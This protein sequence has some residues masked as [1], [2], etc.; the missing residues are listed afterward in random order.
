MSKNFIDEVLNNAPKLVV[1]LL[2]LL[3]LI[4]VSPGLIGGGSPTSTPLPTVPPR[5]LANSEN[6]PWNEIWRKPVYLRRSFQNIRNLIAADEGVLFMDYTNG[7]WL[8]FAEAENGDMRWRVDLNG[9]VDSMVSDGNQVYVFGNAGQ[10][11]DA[12]NLLNGNL[13]WKANV[14]LPDHRGYSANLQENILYVYDT[15]NHL[16]SISSESGSLIKDMSPPNFG[17]EFLSNIEG[18][19]WL[20]SKDKQIILANGEEIMWQ[21]ELN[22]APQKFPYIYKNMVIVR[23]EN[24]RSVFDGIAGISLSNGE[25]LWQRPDEFYSN[26]VISEDLLYVISKDVSILVLDPEN[27]KTVGY[28]ELQPNNIWNIHPVSAIAVNENMLYVY[29]TDSGELIAFEKTVSN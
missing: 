15:R 28:A 5:A 10:T 22:G 3:G 29:F 1:G 26:F 18:D 7:D 23:F 20:V 24:D 17:G 19:D 13:V 16:Y 8:A 21:T 12:Y 14:W 2:F 27:G 6:F 4:F 25:L 9:T 11:K